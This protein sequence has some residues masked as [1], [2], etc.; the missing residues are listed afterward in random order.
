[1]RITGSKDV[2]GINIA[3]N[4]HSGPKPCLGLTKVIKNVAAIATIARNPNGGLTLRKD[5]RSG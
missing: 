5:D 1:M 4:I 2:P 3:M